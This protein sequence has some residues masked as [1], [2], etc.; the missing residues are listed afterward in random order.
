ME[1][2]EANPLDYNFNEDER[3]YPYGGFRKE[4][5]EDDFHNFTNNVKEFYIQEE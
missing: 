2:E 4:L 1:A 3:I 5:I